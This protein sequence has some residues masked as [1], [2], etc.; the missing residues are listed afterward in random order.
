MIRPLFAIPISVAKIIALLAGYIGAQN[1]AQSS[2]LVKFR[3]FCM[4]FT[5]MCGSSW[6]PAFVRII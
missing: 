6:T 5:Q 2:S 4:Q 3:H 1:G